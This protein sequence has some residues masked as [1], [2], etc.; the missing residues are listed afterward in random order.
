VV[1]AVTGGVAASALVGARQTITAFDRFRER[2]GD[3]DVFLHVDDPLT[4]SEL[5]AVAALEDARAVHTMTPVRLAGDELGLDPRR[6]AVL[7]LEDR[8]GVPGG[9]RLVEGSAPREGASEVTIDELGA[10]ALRIAPGDDLALPLLVPASGCRAVRGHCEELEVAAG[11]T[12]RVVGI[13][14]S[15]VDL[16]PADATDIVFRGPLTLSSAVDATG[17]MMQVVE[18]R[19]MRVT[20][21]QE[22]FRTAVDEIL[23]VRSP[24]TPDARVFYDPRDLP[25]SV[26]GRLTVERDALVALAVVVAAVGVALTLQLFARHLS[27]LARE[28]RVLQELGMS[29]RARTASG[30]II[31]AV[32]AVAGLG[33]LVVV[34]V[35]AS[36]LFP[37]G[38][39]RRADPDLGLHI[40][41]LALGA[42]L[43]LAGV[44]F[45]GAVAVAALAART[46]RTTLMA[47]AAPTTASRIAEAVGMG[48]VPSTG[49][50]LAFD[51][52]GPR[53]AALFGGAVT[54]GAVGGALVVTAAAF[55]ASAEHLRSDPALYGRPWDAIAM[56]QPVDREVLAAVS[57]HPSVED[58]ALFRTGRVVD[59]DLS[60]AGESHGAWTIEDQVGRSNI[61][62]L[63]GRLPEAADEAAVGAGTE[64]RLGSHVGEAVAMRDASGTVVELRLVG[65]VALPEWDYHLNNVGLLLTPAGFDRLAPIAGQQPGI[66]LTLRRDSDFEAVRDDFAASDLLLEPRDIPTRVENLFGAGQIPTLIGVFGVVVAAVAVANQII[67]VTRHRRH[68]LAVLRALGLTRRGA[69]GSIAWL[70]IDVSLVAL[71]GGLVLG[72]I[73]AR[74]MWTTVAERFGFVPQLE[75]PIGALAIVL[76][77]AV[78]AAAVPVAI[79]ARRAVA[80]R[81]A[82]L[83]R[84]E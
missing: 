36:P 21:A 33:G 23:G 2:T 77:V 8:S 64:S 13:T 67:V 26:D 22:S 82:A 84:A 61:A 17:P 10:S 48:A 19:L 47:R 52:D 76:L 40:D 37:R 18:V 62:L 20:G 12:V 15:P 65:R 34:A 30:A 27:G 63:T 78:T 42:G 80:E 79:A 43:L 45:A 59:S 75:V 39:A 35:A 11:P 68:D 71:L 83:L 16:V 66:G 81:P 38:L 56:N 41:A 1:L 53:S 44:V 4:A 58:V 31:G 74:L 69:L 3:P 50:R 28:Q 5:R 70:S 25:G 9:P 24:E 55:G 54:A 32:L 57:A 73:G 7:M 14:R 72:W 49:A 6:G 60:F 29:R 46:G 51:V